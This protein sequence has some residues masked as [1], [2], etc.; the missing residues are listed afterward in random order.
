[1]KIKN[2]VFDLG[3]VLIDWDPRYLFKKI[4]SDPVEM[5]YFLKNVVNHD[6]NVQ[7]DA[8][9]PFAEAVAE[10]SGK[11]PEYEEQIRIYHSRWPEMLNGP[12]HESVEILKTLVQK[13]QHRILGLSNW[14]HETFPVAQKLYDFLEWFEAIVVSGQI[15][16]KKPDPEIF[17]HLCEIHKILPEESVF[18]DDAAANIAAAQKLG[19]HTV[20]FKTATDLRQQLQKL[21][22]LS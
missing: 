13:K 8:G 11:F 9:R 22:V 21:G 12:I 20:H 15:K 1:M 7:Q 2:V 5:E 6:W 19:F 18:I 14:S 16:M 17:L 10:L 4:F 3:G